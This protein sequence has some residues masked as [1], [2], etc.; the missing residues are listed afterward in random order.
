MSGPIKTTFEA[1]AAAQS[2]T[3]PKRPA[4]FPIRLSPEERSYLEHRAGNRPL[5]TYAREVL[6]GDAQT[7]RKITPRKP[8]IDYPM[9]GQI[10]GLLG[11]S[12]LTSVLCLLAVAAESGS[13]VMDED[14]TAQVKE[15]C[16]DIHEI[17]LILV[18]ALGL[19]P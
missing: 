14:A 18:K 1:V 16:T 8:K 15:A 17:R 13:V 7:P 5:G 4:P 2:I 10:L 12:E 6:L 19:R 9:L 3:K 11:K